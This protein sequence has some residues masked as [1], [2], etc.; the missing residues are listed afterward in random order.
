[1]CTE[2]GGRRGNL[3]RRRRKR[4]RGDL[5]EVAELAEEVGDLVLHAHGRL[6]LLHL[7]VALAYIS[8]VL[9]CLAREERARQRERHQGEVGLQ[10]CDEVRAAFWRQ[11]K[12][13]RREEKER[14][15]RRSEYRWDRGGEEIMG[16]DL[17]G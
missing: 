4:G 17:R 14:K 6:V 15:R 2:E 5:G 1:V 11:G 9:L 10:R 16:A 8:N 12:S 13:E 3:K 7:P